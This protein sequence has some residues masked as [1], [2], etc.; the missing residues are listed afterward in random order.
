MIHELPLFS[1]GCAPL[2]ATG[3]PAEKDVPEMN[4]KAPLDAWKL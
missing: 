4:K 1:F 2:A 3:I